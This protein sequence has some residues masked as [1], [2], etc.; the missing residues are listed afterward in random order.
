MSGDSEIKLRLSKTANIK[1]STCLITRGEL[2]FGVHKSDQGA[3]NLQKIELFLEDTP[4]YGMDIETTNIYGKLKASVVELFGPKDKSKRRNTKTESLGF[5]DND[6][7]IASIA[8]Q[9][10]LILVSADA[11]IQ[12]LQG[13]IGL[14]VESW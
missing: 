14:K 5:K 8:I 4:L 13:I 7:W 12:K 11:H 2:M 3:E 6:L 9:H 1:I 10:N